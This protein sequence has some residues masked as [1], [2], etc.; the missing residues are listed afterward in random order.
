MR[1]TSD[2]TS[3]SDPV[4]AREDG[5]EGQQPAGMDVPHPS[6]P[7]LADVLNGAHEVHEDKK[8][9]KDM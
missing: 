3:D 6:R 1:S 9:G 2:L 7:T 4:H 5:A 8:D